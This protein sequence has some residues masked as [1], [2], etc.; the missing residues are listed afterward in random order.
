MVR[1]IHGK[2]LIK[3]LLSQHPDTLPTWLDKLSKED[4]PVLL[5][6]LQGIQSQLL[7]QGDVAVRTGMQDFA[8]IATGISAS[9]ATP[10]YHPVARQLLF[11]EED[12]LKSLTQEELTKLGAHRLADT[13][14]KIAPNATCGKLTQKL[15][16]AGDKWRE[17]YVSLGLYAAPGKPF[18]ITIPKE[19]LE[20]QPL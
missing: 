10:V 4:M 15:N 17:E 2:K 20:V 12:W 14:G 5:E 1:E 19:Q 3:D 11:M 13:L 16:S 6:A 7:T 9:V 18:T 8:K